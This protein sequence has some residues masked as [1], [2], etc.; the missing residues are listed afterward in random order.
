MN[1]R[2]IRSGSAKPTARVQSFQRFV[3]G[4]HAGRA[5][6]ARSFSMALAGVLAGLGSEG[7]VEL[8]AAQ[9]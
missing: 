1:A 5:A 6:S 4:L 7:A 2:R 9:V 3:A 8:A